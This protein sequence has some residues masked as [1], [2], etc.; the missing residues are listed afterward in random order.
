MG[1]WCCERVK[2]S[3]SVSYSVKWR[4]GRFAVARLSPAPLPEGRKA[5]RCVRVYM[6]VCV[7]VCARARSI[8]WTLASIA[9]PVQTLFAKLH[10]TSRVRARESSILDKVPSPLFRSFGVDPSGLA[11]S[12]LNSLPYR[13]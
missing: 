2:T 4:N 8:E 5:S 10:C 1:Y 7:Y 6:Y 12:V 9:G 3:Q 11:R 13:Q